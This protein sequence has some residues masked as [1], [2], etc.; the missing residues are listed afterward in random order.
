MVQALGDQIR[1]VSNRADAVGEGLMI[2]VLPRATLG[3]APGILAVASGPLADAQTFLY[4]PPSGDTTVQLGP[5]T[6]CGG[7]I[8][9][10]EAKPLPADYERPAPPPTL[11]SDPPGHARRWYLAPVVAPELRLIHFTW[12]R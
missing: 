9:R 4:V 2:S 8:A 11:A 6:T 1:S 3:S 5:V 10:F 12:T 7:G